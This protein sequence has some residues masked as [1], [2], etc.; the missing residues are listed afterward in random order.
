MNQM[1]NKLKTKK[2]DVFQIFFILIILFV[3]AIV[4]LLIA[5]LSTGITKS[6]SEMQIIKDN[7]N[8]QLQNQK[9][10]QNAVPIADMFVFFIF[11]FG[12]ISL[13]IAATRTSFS[14]TLI[15]LFIIL[16]LFAI[17]ISA[18]M[19]NV[20]QGLAH[21]TVLSQTSQGM[22]LTGLIFSKYFPLFICVISGIVFIFMYGKSGSDINP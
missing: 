14:P 22:S 12:N 15:F 9:V 3:V 6:I 17:V 2:G 18:G 19:V 1:K 4:G 7:P 8:A 10:S 20:Y 16:F 5:T 13:I 11:L 21:D